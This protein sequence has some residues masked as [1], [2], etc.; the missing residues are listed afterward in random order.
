MFD[1]LTGLKID[2]EMIKTRFGELI[3]IG[4]VEEID[5]VKG[6]RIKLADGEDG[7]FLSPWLPHP[8]SGGQ[9]SS[10]MPLSKGQVVG[11][12]SPNGDMRQGVLLRSGFTEQNQPPSADLLANILKAFGI[13]ITMK[14]G[15]L[16]VEGDVK[17]IG[18]VEIEGDLK[19]TG[20][21]DF[22][23]GHVKHNDTNIGDDH[24]HGGI[25]KGAD[26]TLGPH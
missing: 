16:T 12:L 18:N 19:V 17:I 3:R 9:S 23:S 4:P 25:V 22:Y 10:W 21:V 7:S 15:T 5:P 8:E 6:Y 11:I 13:T 14:D 24:V 20:N 2:L 1:F 26:D